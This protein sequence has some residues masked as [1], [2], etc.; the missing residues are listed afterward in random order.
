M[1]QNQDDTKENASVLAD[2]KESDYADDN[3]TTE[4]RE[5]GE[6]EED[7]GERVEETTSSG[8]INGFTD[9]DENKYYEKH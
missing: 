5:G 1:P 9:R 4:K 8:A 7:G 6:N 3:V 2:E